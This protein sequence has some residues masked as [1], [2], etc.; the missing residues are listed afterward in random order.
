MDD[1]R[2][3][4]SGEGKYGLYGI[5]KFRG[6]DNARLDGSVVT[7]ASAQPDQNGSIAVSLTMNNEGEDLGRHDPESGRQRQP[8]DRHRTR[9]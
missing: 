8:R 6:S 2:E 3:G 7:N 4:D 9:R 5:K 1:G